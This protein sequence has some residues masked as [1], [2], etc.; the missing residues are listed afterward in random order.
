MDCSPLGSGSRGYEEGC[1]DRLASW[2]RAFCGAEREGIEV[3][4]IHTW[5]VNYVNKAVCNVII[6]NAP[7]QKQY[8]EAVVGDGNNALDWTRSDYET[9]W[10]DIVQFYGIDSRDQYLKVSRA[11]S[12]KK[13]KR[14]GRAQIW[15]GL[16]AYRAELDKRGLMDWPDV[17]RKARQHLEASG[18]TPYRSIVIDE[19]QDIDAEQWRLLKVLAPDKD[20]NLF[21]TGDGHQRIYGKPI[22]L[23]HFGINIRGRARRLK[24]NYRTTEQVLR[25]ATGLL[26]GADI[27]DLDGGTDNT[28]GYRSLYS[29]PEPEIH[30]FDSDRE[31]AKF[32]VERIRKLIKDS[33]PEE[34]AVVTKYK[35]TVGAFSDFLADAGIENIVLDGDSSGPGVR[36]ATMHRV[37][38][39]DFSHV[40]MHL[41]EAKGDT[42]DP[43]DQ[44]LLYV[45]ATRC[46]KT[47]TVLR[48]GPEL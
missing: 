13:L 16:A 2:I 37:K 48:A 28:V 34:I 33:P 44:S 43:R 31:Q 23:A 26:K 25:W 12:K 45:A 46:R 30:S 41:P 6:P 3:T 7:Q 9:E 14:A 39:L 35:K 4:N 10:K 18:E 47:L 27:D 8:W 38:G 36:L 22:V 20:N 5:A 19:A 24:I 32:L 11:G 40:I 42:K 17:V 21:I 1:C 29:G 15:E